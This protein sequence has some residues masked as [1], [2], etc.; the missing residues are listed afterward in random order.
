MK[1][2]ILFTGERV[3]IPLAFLAMMPAQV[4]MI[5]WAVYAPG[6]TRYEDAT[7]L[8]RLL[9][10]IELKRGRT[11]LS[12]ASVVTYMPQKENAA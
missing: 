7:R 4:G 3:F 10:M 6:W 5:P 2:R 8:Q 12:S 9:Q 1:R 11:F